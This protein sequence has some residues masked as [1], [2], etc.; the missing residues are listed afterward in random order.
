MDYVTK[1]GS[2]HPE[3]AARFS[4]LGRLFQK[5]LW[6]QL[7]QK[8]L[9][10]STLDYFQSDKRLI[11]LYENFVAKFAKRINQLDLVTLAI[12]AS[13]QY[14]DEKESIGFLETVTKLVESD[15]QAAVLC[16]METARR[17]LDAGRLDE[18]KALLEEGKKRMDDYMG[19]MD[20][21]VH[22]HFYETS[23]QYNKAKGRSSEHFKNG[24]LYLTYTPLSRIPIHEQVYLAADIALAAI[25]GEDV[26]N[27][28]ELLQQP[29]L[30]VLEDTKM[31]W[32]SDLLKAFNRGD[33]SKF[34]EIFAAHKYPEEK[35][36]P[37]LAKHES[38]LNEKIRI[39]AFMEM[40]LVRSAAKRKLEFSEIA[41]RCDLKEEEVELML[42][43]AFSLKVVRGVIDE[44]DK[45]VRI[46]WVQPRVL[47]ISQISL[48]RDR[49]KEWS[50]NI[51]KTA[52]YLEDN[53]PELLQAAPA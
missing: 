2:A 29:I 5:K 43:K 24:L 28:G 40:V 53:A 46:K 21:V 37:S 14:S 41:K 18:C 22:S 20:A 12:A 13:K 3:Q 48:I 49:L 51:H 26:Y 35:W 16:R 45:S 31:Q 23:L 10:L 33:V 50:K 47:E 17:L 25:L 9:E 36:E 11:S 32:V 1:E 15:D 44:V 39:L 30:K 52:L 34:H 42:M 6:Y 27:F 19:I 8:L 7:S 38:F 4:E